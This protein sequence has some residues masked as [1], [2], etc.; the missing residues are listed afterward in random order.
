MFES[1]DILFRR[2]MRHVE[3]IGTP[4]PWGIYQQPIRTLFA[5]SF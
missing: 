2:P 1:L 5:P 4:F 3:A